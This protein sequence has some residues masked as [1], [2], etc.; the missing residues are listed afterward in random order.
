[1]AADDTV[2]AL[3]AGTRIGQLQ[4]EVVSLQAHV[5][6]LTAAGHELISTQ[7][8]MQSLLHRASDGIIQ[9]ESDGTV[10]SFNLAAERIF[11]IAEIELL[12]QS[13]DHLFDLP[14]QFRGNV[15]GFLQAFV[16]TT[17]DQYHHPLRGV[18]ADGSIRLLEVSVAEIESQDLLLFDD[19][20]HSEVG[21]ESGYEAFLCILH[22]IT[23]RK[24]IDEE[25][26]RHREEL[27]QLVAEQTAEIV[28]A[29]EEAE[30][31]N[32][33]KSEF[34]ASMSH[35]LRTPMHAILSYSE[36]GQKKLE[37][38][39]LEKLGQYFDRIQ[40]AGTRLLAMINDLLDLSKAE[41]GRQRYNIAEHDVEAMIL[42]IM[43]EYEALAGRRGIRIE[44]R[45]QSSDQLADVDPEQ[46]GQ[47][48]RNLLS[49]A[50]KFSPD[51]G[52]VIVTL[53]A[54]D[55]SNDAEKLTILVRDQGPGIPPD[56][57]ETIFDKFVQSRRNNA[58]MGGTGLGLAI[59]REAVLAHGGT[60]SAS[61]NPEGG[62][63]FRIE[64]PRRHVPDETT[65][66]SA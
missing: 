49:N 36:L 55:L 7:T 32:Q 2:K 14:E 38:A 17:S 33:A 43:Q 58:A 53:A 52:D 15:P 8:R 34:L 3:P 51:D 5:D 60:L 62:A 39:N 56:E 26:R 41:A 66:Q 48:V 19:F 47:V 44:C 20:S 54:A 18:R 50:I 16:R 4:A 42:A 35:E 40:K 10:S 12:H 30:K 64:F 65:P 9:F 61:N 45:C 57:L 28:S 59:A 24:Q 46:M 63:C 13:P 22:D 1:M 27:E 6:Q 31:A 23:E 25:L 29:K 21:D 37:T 11:D